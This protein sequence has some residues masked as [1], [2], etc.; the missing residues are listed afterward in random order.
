[1]S[2]LELASILSLAAVGTGTVTLV[3]M[4]L[5]Q[6]FEGSD[7]ACLLWFFPRL[8]VTARHTK[9]VKCLCYDH[10]YLGIQALLKP[11]LLLSNKVFPLPV[12]LL[13]DTFSAAYHDLS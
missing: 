12:D 10:S 8:L 1:M 4:A 3:Q 5:E 11:L 9:L 7:S 6:D 13:P 2:L